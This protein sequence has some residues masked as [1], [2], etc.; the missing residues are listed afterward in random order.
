[1]RV[2]ALRMRWIEFQNNPN[3]KE[4]EREG[5]H[6]AESALR[7]RDAAHPGTPE[8]ARAEDLLADM[9]RAMRGITG[10]SS[11]KL[12]SLEAEYA[13][14]IVRPAEGNPAK[15]AGA[16]GKANGRGAS[17]GDSDQMQISEENE[18]PVNMLRRKAAAFE[19]AGGVRASKQNAKKP[20]THT[21]AKP[22]KTGT[23]RPKF[24]R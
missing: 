6:I 8:H 18:L 1:M 17:R 2:D 11:A 12:K 22:K 19:A 7:M 24:L 5:L 14:D 21:P 3:K 4:K 13:R 23:W 10:E 15:G 20:E 16:A 9:R